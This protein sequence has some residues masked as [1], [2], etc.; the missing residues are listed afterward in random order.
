M[1]E[2]NITF[3]L[4]GRRNQQSNV[5]NVSKAMHVSYLFVKGT[6]NEINIKVLWRI[7][8]LI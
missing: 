4:T 5:I 8:G 6:F 2:I 3:T 1:G 7:Y